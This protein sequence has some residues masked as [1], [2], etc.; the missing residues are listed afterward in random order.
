MTLVRSRERAQTVILL[1]FL[2]GILM[3]MAALVVDVGSTHRVRT[4]THYVADAAALGGVAQLLA[5]ADPTLARQ[6]AL[7]ICRLNGYVVGQLGVTRIDA[8][9]FNHQVWPDENPAAIDVP[10]SDRYQVTIHRELP[11]YFASIIGISRTGVEQYAVAAILNAAPG[12]VGLG[13]TLG[14]PD[15]A[16]LSQFGPDALYSFGDCYSPRKLDNGAPN[17]RYNPDGYVYDIVVPEDLEQATGSSFVRIEIF[18]PDTINMAPHVRVNPF[19]LQ[20]TNSK[21]SDPERGA[22]DEI[23]WPYGHNAVS[24][25]EFGPLS[26]QTQ[27][28]LY[29]KTGATIATCTYGPQTNTPFWY[30][31]QAPTAGAATVAAHA[32]PAQAQSATDL[33]WVTPPRFEFD[34]K[35]YTA[36]F[37]MK[38]RTLSGS[39]ENGFSLRASV[40]RANGV[41][42][43]PLQHAITPGGALAMYARGRLPINFHDSSRTAVPIANIPSHAKD[44]TITNF[45]CVVGAQNME[46]T[47]TGYDQSTGQ[48][49][50]PILLPA[51]PSARGSNVVTDAAGT[52]YYTN[53][54]GTLSGNAEFATDT[55]DLP[56]QVVVPQ[57]DGSGGL[58]FDRSGNIVI[59]DKRPFE[60]C[61]IRITYTAGAHD[62]SVWEVSFTGEPGS[63]QQHIV[64]IR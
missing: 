20:N 64:L 35:L 54:P 18:D 16:N 13:G 4:E 42:F 36:P 6:R 58:V 21:D 23:R 37:A 61:D 43:D 3:V 29:D 14:F 22:I 62:S 49:R 17:P 15:E 25:S 40:Q 12:D 57:T 34:T 26:T 47:L 11:Q 19:K 38:V 53:Q 45:D 33:H 41:G 2:V 48:G 7:E 5:T 39:S 30:Q 8:V 46:F 1:T 32:D 60:G 59:M 10:N 27:Y 28:I 50:Y 31:T 24:E 55:I 56:D 63:G 9:A 52:K 44:V 51:P